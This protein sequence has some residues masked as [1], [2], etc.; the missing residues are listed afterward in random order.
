[1]REL[2]REKQVSISVCAADHGTRVHPLTSLQ[3]SRTCG[4][5]ATMPL[6]LYRVTFF[7]FAEAPR[8][9]E[10]QTTYRKRTTGEGV[11]SAAVYGVRNGASL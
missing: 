7:F 11:K 1:M 4:I 5:E 9:T 3:E 2:K 6:Q 10:R 8:G